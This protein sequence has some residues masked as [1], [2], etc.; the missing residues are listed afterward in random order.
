MGLRGH[1]RNVIVITMLVCL[2]AIALIQGILVPALESHSGAAGQ[3][4]S[5]RDAASTGRLLGSLMAVASSESGGRPGSLRGAGAAAGEADGFLWP[6]PRGSASGNSMWG[7]DLGPP[8]EELWHLHTGR[9]FFA[10]PALAGD[11][12]Y[13]GCN[14]GFF[15]ALDVDN[16]NVAWSMPTSCGFCGEAAVDSARAYVGGQ[17]GYVYAIDRFSGTREWSAGL[18]YH[19]FAGTALA[20]DSLVVTGNSAGS[21]AALYR[22]DG[23]LCWSDC[24]G[25]VIL[26]PAV[27]DSTIVFTS[28]AGGV[29]AYDLCGGER[30]AASFAGVASAPSLDPA[31]VYVGFSD[32][33]VRRL[34]L[35]DGRVGW[36]TDLTSS[37][38]RS[39]VSR[40]VLTDSM[41]LV[42]TCDN[43]LV[44]L[45]R[46]SGDILWESHFDNWMQVPPAIGDSVAYAPGDDQILHMIDLSTGE[47]MD[48]LEMDG[49]AGTPPVVSGDRIFFGTAM[50]DLYAYR[51][52]PIE[53]DSLD[54]NADATAPDLR[55]EGEIAADAGTDAE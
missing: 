33:T 24:P 1:D 14:D 27:H 12:I 42:G 48:S 44:C 3:A 8:F 50:G 53:Y 55:P 6:Q 31:W 38:S 22:H 4:A 40:P 2:L 20:G 41:V 18:G 15:R 29:H 34:G 25:G 16:G 49:Y 9:E 39:L 54:S 28:E 46:S 45:G 35:L 26:G 52:V 37:A 51:G 5:G 11:M 23:S 10:G 43:R 7:P 17:D 30:W 21:I 19:I 47:S 32:G 13:I 36:S